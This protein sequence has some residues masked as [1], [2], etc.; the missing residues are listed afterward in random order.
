MKMSV[1]IVAEVRHQMQY[2]LMT[3][4]SSQV[5]HAEKR[6]P[7]PESRVVSHAVVRSAAPCNPDSA[8][9]SSTM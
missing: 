8:S 6:T 3:N 4:D 1:M 2:P 5:N 9:T 7:Q